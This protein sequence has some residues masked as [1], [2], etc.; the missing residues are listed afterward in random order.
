VHFVPKQ[1]KEKNKRLLMWRMIW[2]PNTLSV[3]ELVGLLENN[4]HNTL[5]I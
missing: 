2:L 1:S 4:I 5:D 3:N